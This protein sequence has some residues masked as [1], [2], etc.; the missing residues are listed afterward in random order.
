MTILAGLAAAAALAVLP[1]AP[2]NAAT[3]VLTING[4]DRVDPAGCHTLDAGP[5][6]VANRTDA[7]VFIVS[8]RDCTGEVRGVLLPGQT[9]TG[10]GPGGGVFAP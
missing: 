3:G 1:A 2:A 8:G 10:Q 6:K 5:Y 4:T 7:T 9:G